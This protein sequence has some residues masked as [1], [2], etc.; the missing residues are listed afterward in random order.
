MNKQA[1]LLSHDL[2]MTEQPDLQQT[3]SI[4]QQL[5][6]RSGVCSADIKDETDI[7]FQDKETGKLTKAHK[8]FLSQASPFFNTW[9]KEQWQKVKATTE[10][11]VP[12]DIDWEVFTNVI[13][14]MYGKEVQFEE[15]AL[16]K[17]YNAA[18]FLQL[19]ILK[20]AIVVSLTD[21]WELKDPSIVDAM[22]TAIASHADPRVVSGLLYLVSVRYLIRNIPTIVENDNID[23]SP[24]PLDTVMEIAQSEEVAAPEIQLYHFLRKWT[25]KNGHK[26]TLDQTLNLFGHIRYA[27]IPHSE[28]E[29]ITKYP[30]NNN[31][32]L[33]SALGSCPNFLEGMNF[34][35]EVKQF[36]NRKYQEGVLLLNSPQQKK[37]TTRIE[38]ASSPV[39]TIVSKKRE[40]TIVLS[41]SMGV[42]KNITR[43]SIAT[44][45]EPYYVTCEIDNLCTLGSSKRHLRK[46]IHIT[47]EPKEE[48]NKPSTGGFVASVM[49]PAQ[50]AACRP[51]TAGL[52]IRTTPNEVRLELFDGTNTSITVNYPHPWL[53]R[54]DIYNLEMT[55]IVV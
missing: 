52:V 29:T 8:T 13:S 19:D 5:T 10:Y 25:E 31:Y 38:N 9:F 30:A 27:T 1:S 16:P 7:V 40:C 37:W 18:D 23:I 22:C 26:L 28:L 12:G 14:F 46:D 45:T 54:I 51:S 49:P 48:A 55:N 42:L 47:K 39:Y 3:V 21:Q 15:E 32:K 4:S 34:K 2:K 36:T 17:I 44:L 20:M 33:W 6:L 50:V 41:W 43:W 11:P 24:L 53:L 35:V